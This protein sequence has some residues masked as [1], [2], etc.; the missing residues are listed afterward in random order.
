[1]GPL[2]G[3]VQERG[4]ECVDKLMAEV[5]RLFDTYVD[6]LLSLVST[7]KQACCTSSIG[8]TRS[9]M[10]LLFSLIRRS[11]PTI[12]SITT[13]SMDI[14]MK[15][16]FAIIWS[17]GGV[18]TDESERVKFDV[19][20][21]DL[22]RVNDGVC[23]FPPDLSVYDYVG[24]F[25]LDE[26][27]Q[28]SESFVD[29]VGGWRLWTVAFPEAQFDPISVA[30]S[31]D[32][33]LFLNE[34]MVPTKDTVRLGFL[35]SLNLATLAP[36]LFVGPTSTGKSK[37]M[38]QHLQALS[39]T[40]LPFSTNFTTRTTAR[41]AQ[42]TLMSKLEK[43][44]KGTYG[45]PLG[46]T[47]N[48]FIDDLNRTTVEKYGAQPPV[49]LLRQLLDHGSWFDETH[50]Y[51]KMEIVNVLLLGATGSI[52]GGQS[53]PTPRFLRHFHCVSVNLFDDETLNTIYLT[54]LSVH[55]SNFTVEVQSL[56]KQVFETIAQTQH[57]IQLVTASIS[58]FKSITSRFLPTP[59]TPHYAFNLRNLSRVFHGLSLS[60]TSLFQKPLKFIRLWVH[61]LIREFQDRLVSEADRDWVFM[62]VK[63]TIREHLCKDMGKLFK[64]LIVNAPTSDKS[65][66]PPQHDLQST[67]L[68][69]L[70]FGT[71]LTEGGDTLMPADSA[72]STTIPVPGIAEK[73][74]AHKK[75][76]YMEL[77]NV[78]EV[79]E[80]ILRE[81]GA[82]NRVHKKQLTSIPFSYAIQ[83]CCRV[84][85]ILQMH[86]GNALLLGVGGS[87]RQTVTRL[88]AHLSSMELVQIEMMKSYGITE[89]RDD[90]RKVLKRCGCWDVS[91]VF[92]FS[93]AQLKSG[94]GGGEENEGEGEWVLEDLNNL[95]TH[96]AIPSALFTV[97]D[98]LSLLDESTGSTNAT[99]NGRTDSA[100]DDSASK[101]IAEKRV[102]DYSE[103]VRRIK[104]NL[105]VVLCL[106]P[107]GDVFRQ[108]LR[109]FPSLLNC[110]SVNWFDSWP[111]D[112]LRAV[113]EYAL[114]DLNLLPHLRAPITSACIQFHMDA[115]FESQELLR[116][117]HRHCYV[118][119][120]SYI[121][122]LSRY[123]FLLNRRRYCPSVHHDFHSHNFA[124]PSWTRAA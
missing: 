12:F 114:H 11:S 78:A 95:L 85:R 16:L 26:A 99:L 36:T 30:A 60:S 48:V 68:Q 32:S 38:L 51:S 40:H 116:V 9:S 33:D 109:Q 53:N 69:L 67:D 47:L 59:A 97:E 25:T 41:Q 72:P 13:G 1:M 87:G 17:I 106:S 96:A 121:E 100:G 64:H 31:A 39:H 63:A 52:G 29:G 56:T 43:R 23:C 82:Y 2:I 104:R 22:V 45:P 118:T 61:E 120:T 108:R 89:W 70:L 81:L 113:S 19:G 10:S 119:P 34:I 101:S 86:G 117:H 66:V 71:H 54:L 123:H 65:I 111:D 28:S 62:A 5:T 77:T 75:I 21:R 124:V 4:L 55:L 76:A 110:Y 7:M 98:R 88:A 83:H 73:K 84:N 3:V 6:A 105:H 35:L 80:V 42:A 37:V 44:K 107:V 74:V 79:A 24:D 20:L 90:L 57:F 15:F 50:G 91:V 58:L 103:F 94:G 18:L 46:H 14:T 112:A 49:E 93:D 115:I 8:L 27:G 122:F 92:L 102:L